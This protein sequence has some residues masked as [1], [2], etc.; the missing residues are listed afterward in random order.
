MFLFFLGKL[1]SHIIGGAALDEPF[2]PPVFHLLPYMM[3]DNTKTLRSNVTPPPPPPPFSIFSYP[4][5]FLFSPCSYE[6]NPSRDPKESVR[7][8]KKEKLTATVEKSDGASDKFALPDTSNWWSDCPVTLWS[9]GQK[10]T[11]AQTATPTATQRNQ[12]KKKKKK[13]NK[14]KSGK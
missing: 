9:R 13:K 4:P 11:V 12:K 1:L 5:S 7:F 14:S 6:V 8:G 3:R 10:V 2:P